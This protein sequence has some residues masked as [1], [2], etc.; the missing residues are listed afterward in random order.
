MKKNQVNLK[1][2][3]SQTIIEICDGIADAKS[4]SVTTYDNG[5]VA[6]Y[7]IDGE[8]Q[9]TYHLINFDILIDVSNNTNTKMGAGVDGAVNIYLAA[10]KIGFFGKWGF[11]KHK[12]INTQ[13]RIT[14]SVPYVPQGLEIPQGL[15]RNNDNKK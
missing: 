11:E 12:N 4:H 9:S 3:I 13:Q 1:K 14:F 15:K 7:K 6:P 2:F 10:S 5:L 8:I